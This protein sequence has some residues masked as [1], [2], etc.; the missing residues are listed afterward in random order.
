[1]NMDYNSPLYQCFVHPT[2]CR[3]LLEAGLTPHLP[4][5]YRITDCSTELNTYAFDKDDYY[6]E[7]DKLLDRW[8]GNLVYLPAFQLKDVEKCL[9][10][11]YLVQHNEQGYTLM[12]ENIYHIPEQLDQRLP[13]VFARA[14]LEGI[15]ARVIRVDY[16]NQLI[17]TI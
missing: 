16:V 17:S 4:Y 5:H 2:L 13:D 6:A 3:Q 9:P 15:R 14:V 1:M 8:G 11:H 10:G 7:G 12:L